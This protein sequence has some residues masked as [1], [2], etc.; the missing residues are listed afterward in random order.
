MGFMLLDLEF[1]MYVLLIVVCPFVL[2]ILAIVF[3]GIRRY[4]DSDYPFG[5]FKLFLRNRE[6]NLRWNEAPVQGD[7]QKLIVSNK[8]V[9]HFH[10]V[11]LNVNI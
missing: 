5:F 1:Y 10:D 8:L 6:W 3:S 4:T 7:K 9:E 11:V 2:F